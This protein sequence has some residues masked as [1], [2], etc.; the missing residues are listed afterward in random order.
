MF[1]TRRVRASSFYLVTNA[2]R[3]DVDIPWITKHVE[4]WNGEHSDKVE[5][6]VFDSSALIALQGAHAPAPRQSHVGEKVT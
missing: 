2:G 3:S 4:A 5:F 1:P 6:K